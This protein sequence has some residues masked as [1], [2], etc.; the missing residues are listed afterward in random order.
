MVPLRLHQTACA[1]GPSPLWYSTRRQNSRLKILNRD[2]LAMTAV[3]LDINGPS[4]RQHL[5]RLRAGE[6]ADD[7][8]ES[9]DLETA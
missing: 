3:R 2:R 6:I 4:Y 5:A 9:P 8:T 7:A 1:R